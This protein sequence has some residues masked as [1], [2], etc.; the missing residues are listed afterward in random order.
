MDLTRRSP[1][2]LAVEL[3]AQSTHPHRRLPSR[4]IAASAATTAEIWHHHN[5]G[6]YQVP[7]VLPETKVERG[8]IKIVNNSHP[9]SVGS[10]SPA[11]N[12]SSTLSTGGGKHRELIIVVSGRGGKGKGRFSHAFSSTDL[13]QSS[14]LSSSPFLHSSNSIALSPLTKAKSG[15]LSAAR[16]GTSHF[17]MAV[18]YLI[19]RLQRCAAYKCVDPI[20]I[21]G[22]KHPSQHSNEQRPRG[23]RA[24][25]TEQGSLVGRRRC[26]VSG[27]GCTSGSCRAST[28][29]ATHPPPLP[30]NPTED[31]LAPL[32]I[33]VTVSDMVF[34]FA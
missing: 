31:T 32:G 25:R 12:N 4:L 10:M 29:T 26:S 17:D 14:Q 34:G 21:L 3:N 7:P 5:E 27:Y 1:A 13:S 33:P 23:A 9:P 22:V 11:V 8:Q 24:G 19:D 16:Y 2:G 18:R 30:I 20:W 6:Q 15:P 28:L